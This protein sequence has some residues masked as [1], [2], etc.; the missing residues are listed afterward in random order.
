MK[1]AL[2]NEKLFIEIAGVGVV[3][4]HRNVRC[5]SSAAHIIFY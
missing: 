4:L 3:E 1:A 2:K 5:I